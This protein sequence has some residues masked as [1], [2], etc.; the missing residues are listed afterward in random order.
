MTRFLKGE[1]LNYLQVRQKWQ[2]TQRD[3]KVSDVVLIKGEDTFR[4]DW[5]RGRVVEVYPSRDGH[6]RR[7]KLKIGTPRQGG[8][9]KELEIGSVIVRPIHKLVLLLPSES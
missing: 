9:T 4:N 2:Q 8:A 5:C 1:Y 6:I 3:A 7:V